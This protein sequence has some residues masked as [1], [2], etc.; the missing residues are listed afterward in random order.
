MDNR[1]GGGMNAVVERSEPVDRYLALAKTAGPLL[2]GAQ[3]EWL[4]AQRE[5]ALDYF[6][7]AGFPTRKQEAWR[8]TGL[9]PVLDEAWGIQAEQVAEHVKAADIA[10]FG[11][12]DDA[13]ARLVF[14][15]G[16]WQRE[17][18]SP[19]GNLPD[20]LQLDGLRSALEASPERLEALLGKVASQEASGFSALNTALF[21]DGVWLQVAAGTRL[22]G[23]VEIVY[24][25][26]G[27]EKYASHPRNLLVLE[28]GAEATVVEHYASLDETPCFTNSVT[29]IRLG[30]RA[31]LEHLRLQDQNTA[32]RHLGNVFIEQEQ[33]SRLRAVSVSLG[34]L[35]ARCEYHNHLQH[36]G[37]SCGIDGLYVAGE[38][39]LADVHLDVD[40]AVPA[41]RSRLRFRG[42]LTGRGRAVFDGLIRVRPDAQ[43]S[44]ARLSNDNLMLSRD[45]EIDTKPQ[46]EIY[47]DDVKCSHGTTVGQLDTGQLF[48]LRSRGI[49]ADAARRMLCLGFAAQVLQGCSVDGF[50][51]RIEQRLRQHLESD[52]QVAGEGHD[53]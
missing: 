19:V 1:G 34:G 53:V 5:R 36:S 35:W 20:G 41:C 13:V 22:S 9:G 6:M 16:R 25:S 28:D 49:G 29:E 45:A 38:R 33:E 51:A 39:R 2:P 50:N 30:K 11:I 32:A 44:D 43:K 52:G 8:Y 46:L 21:D 15:N 12:A 14:V 10:R 26:T 4:A 23:P 48:Y 18:S 7:Q 17:L 37:A 47:A 40:H 3:V 27:R 42:I 31:G 24:L